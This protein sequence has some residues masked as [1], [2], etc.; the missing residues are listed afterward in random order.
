MTDDG[1]LTRAIEAGVVEAE[2]RL[3][4]AEALKKTGRRLG[5]ETLVRDIHHLMARARHHHRAYLQSGD[6]R[7]K[8][9]WGFLQS[10]ALV[11]REALRKYDPRL[12]M[13]VWRTLHRL[14]TAGLWD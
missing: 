8:K 11:F 5:K 3:D 7:Q 1:W 10:R 2:R 12:A 9:F 13:R 4:E 14:N 6:R